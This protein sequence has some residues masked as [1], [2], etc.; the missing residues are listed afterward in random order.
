MLNKD[1]QAEAPNG[2][3][4]LAIAVARAADWLGLSDAVLAEILGVSTPQITLIKAG[5]AAIGAHSNAF[6]AAVL[7]VRVARSLEVLSAG[8]QT[9][10]RAWINSPNSAFG[11]EPSDRMA[12]SQELAEVVAYLD[13]RVARI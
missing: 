9:I 7:L 13:R 11:A 10:A 8:D 2:G 6:E 3:V 12:S 5:K 1:G 4:T